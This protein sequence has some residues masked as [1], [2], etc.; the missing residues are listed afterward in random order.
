MDTFAAQIETL[1]HQFMRAWMQRDRKAMKSLASRE[2]IFL[3]GSTKAAILDRPSWLDA[4]TG[5][6]RCESY[7]FG[8][9]YVRRHGGFAVFSCQAMIEAKMGAADWSG[10]VWIT[11]LWQRSRIRRNWHLVERVFS[12]PDTDEDMPGAIRQ[13]Q[14]WR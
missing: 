13:L 12:R 7:R 11:D 1:E 4:A 9:I 5:R 2:F 6:F 8:E 14:L 3:L 10:S